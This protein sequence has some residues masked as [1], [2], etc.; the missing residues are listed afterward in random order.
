[1]SCSEAAEQVEEKLNLD[2]AGQFLGNSVTPLC[3]IQFISI[4]HRGLIP[5]PVE[6]ASHLTEESCGQVKPSRCSYSN[7]PLKK[8]QAGLTLP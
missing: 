7:H 5:T 3:V 8:L 2:Q 6:G 1:M 4:Q